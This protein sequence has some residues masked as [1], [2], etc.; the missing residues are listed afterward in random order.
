MHVYL[1]AAGE[2]VLTLLRCMQMKPEVVSASTSKEWVVTLQG[3]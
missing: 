1:L 2:K 3:K